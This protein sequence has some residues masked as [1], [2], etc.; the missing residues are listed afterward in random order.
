M[1]PQKELQLKH[2]LLG[3]VF[4]EKVHLVRDVERGAT[5]KKALAIFAT[6][7]IDLHS[8]TTGLNLN[9]EHRQRALLQTRPS[10]INAWSLAYLPTAW[11]FPSLS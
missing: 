3:G 8:R 4:V 2:P 9:S 11:M 6:V 7:Q 5:S 1:K 10:G